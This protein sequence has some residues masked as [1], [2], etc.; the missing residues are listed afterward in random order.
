MTG[1]VRPNGGSDVS[2][3]DRRGR[4]ISSYVLGAA[5]EIA[6]QAI[7][8]AEKLSIDPAV[9]ADLLEEAAATVSRTVTRKQ[10][11]DGSIQ[12]LQSYLFRA[13]LRRLNKKYKRIL[14]IAE[15][16]QANVLDSRNSV[17]PRTS[18]ENK[19]L[20]DEFLTNCDPLTRDIFC[21][22]I[23]G[24]SWKEIGRAYRIS[25][26]AAESRFNQRLQKVRKRLGL[27]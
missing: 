23:E 27:R 18:F 5:N 9:A 25:R 20:I 2:P 11:T 21:L 14:P 4:P 16:F 10:M 19:I 3:M 26:R 8:Y 6:R 22:R 13:F 7:S 15:A 24:R 1:E 17:D 12:D